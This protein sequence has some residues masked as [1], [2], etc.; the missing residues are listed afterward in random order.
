MFSTSGFREETL[1]FQPK[2]SEFDPL[3]QMYVTKVKLPR[4]EVVHSA[5]DH[6]TDSPFT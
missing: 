5:N 4:L 1:A 6:L 3:W 2:D